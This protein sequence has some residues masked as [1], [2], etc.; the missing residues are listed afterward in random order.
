MSSSSSSC[1]SSSS[2]RSSSSSSRSSSSRSSSSSSRSS[3]SSSRSSSSCSSSSSSYYN[4]NLTYGRATVGTSATLI[5]DANTSR[6]SLIITNTD[7]N[8][9]LFIGPDTSITTSNAIE[10]P[11]GGSFFEDNSGTKL[12]MGAFYGISSS[13]ISVRFWERNDIR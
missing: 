10:V 5:V 12:Y 2:S 3:S 6:H 1:S 11:P 7:T 8:Y 4:T 9:S 13:T